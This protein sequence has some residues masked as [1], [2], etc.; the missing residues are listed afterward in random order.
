METYKVTKEQLGEIFTEGFEASLTTALLIVKNSEREVYT[1]EEV[2]KIL[3][4]GIKATDMFRALA[5]AGCD[6]R[7][8]AVDEV[9]T[10]MK[11]ER[12]N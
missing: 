5:L 7:I 10:R 1:S 3:E 12:E 6:L 9:L 8:K 4:D 11:Q 2:M